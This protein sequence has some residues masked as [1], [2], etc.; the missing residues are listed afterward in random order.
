MLSFS[1]Q[2]PPDTPFSLEAMGVTGSDGLWRGTLTAAG[3]VEE[4]GYLITVS[5]QTWDGYRIIAPNANRPRA[6]TLCA[7]GADAGDLDARRGCYGGSD[8]LGL[9]ARVTTPLAGGDL[10]LTANV[11]DLDAE[12]AGSKVADTDTF[13]EINDLYLRFRTGKTIEQ[14]Q[15][16]VRWTGGLGSA[17]DGDFSVYGVHRTINN[18][19][20]FDV[21]DLSRNGGGL[22]AALGRTA[23]TGAGELG[24]Q[25]G[26]EYELQ[27][28]ERSEV[29]LAFGTGQPTGDPFLD[30]DEDVRSVGLFL[31]GTLE[32]PAGAVV[33]AGLRYDN[34]E[35]TA[36][37]KVP[38]TPENPDDSGTRTMDRVSPSIGVSIPAGSLNVFGSVGTVF[39]T[40]TT[41]ELSNQPD[42]A[43]GFNPNLDPMR[44]ESFEIGVRGAVGS[45]AAFELA[46][47]QTNLRDELVRFEVPGLDDVSF[48]RN[49]GESRHRGLEA[50]LS[51]AST[52]GLFRGD[53]PYTYTDAR[54][55][56]YELDGDDLSDNRI[57]G[58][59]PARLQS[60]VRFTPG[61]VWGEVIGTYLESVQVNDRNT[62]M[63]PEYFLLDLRAGLADVALGT[64]TVSPWV[65]VLNALDRDYI[66]SVAVNAFGGRFFRA[67]S[68]AI[69]PVGSARPIRGGLK[70]GSFRRGV[71]AAR[72]G[73]WQVRAPRFLYSSD[74]IPAWSRR[75]VSAGR[76]P[77]QSGQV[78][79]QSEAHLDLQRLSVD[80][81][82]LGGFG[83]Y[84][85]QVG[86]PGHRPDRVIRD[87][88]P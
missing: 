86:R 51:L 5:G 4:T 34:H 14:Q 18:P 12:N 48:F 82:Q 61:L 53:M 39:E 56:E 71:S 3:T 47:Y 26:I 87:E 11:L 50:T 76:P 22:R 75:I 65:S 25:G 21:I 63:A 72:R 29:A 7:R 85:I 43:G 19:I 52:D 81:D 80:H 83:R 60:S 30:Q 16:G 9:N 67:R 2:D 77:P 66:A 68:R 73:A 69:L 70:H 79:S 59:S 37:D 62:A 74:R 27:N 10:S 64:I 45:V 32:L 28:D 44:G 49:S 20:P 8:R 55:Q 6:D 24:I 41:S 58:I 35:F 33:L 36:T 42:A 57:P 84:L 40:P 46:A 13:R 54:F 31:Q 23:D 15:V 1:T 78:S 38:V 17:L 88:R